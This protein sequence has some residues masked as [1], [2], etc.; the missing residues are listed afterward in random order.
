VPVLD[1]P[2]R[3]VKFKGTLPTFPSLVAVQAQLAPKEL[4]GEETL[5]GRLVVVPPGHQ[6]QLRADT[7][8][9]GIRHDAGGRL[10]IAD[11]TARFFDLGLRVQGSIAIVEGTIH[12]E[13]SFRRCIALVTTDLP[14]VLAN[15]LAAPVRV[16]EVFGNVGEQFFEVEVRGT[17]QDVVKTAPSYSASIGEEVVRLARVPP[18]ASGRVLAAYRYVNQARWLA[19][20]GAHPAQFAGEQLLNLNKAVEVLVPHGGRVDTLR[21]Q[22]RILSLREEIV[23]LLAALAHVRNQVDVGHAAVEVLDTEEHSAMHTFV[24]YATEIVSWLVGHVAQ[25]AAER[26]FELPSLTSEPKRKRDETLSR[27][28]ELLGKINPVRPET[29]LRP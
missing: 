12:D 5:S 9:G 18:A 2:H 3:L 22:L 25:L 29:F 16:V 15:A 14:A 8:N 20:Q 23:E 19:Y 10:P 11:A 1:I 4:F 13:D 7:W 17:F 6:V 24:L 21:E 28:G 26:R 27:L